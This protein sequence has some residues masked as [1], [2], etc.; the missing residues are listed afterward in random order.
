MTADFE[1]IAEETICTCEPANNGAGP[2]WCSGSPTIVRDG[3]RVFAT[4]PETG[5]DAKPLC[6]TRWQLFCRDDGATWQRV[7]VQ[8]NFCEREPCPLLLLPDGRLALS[9]N[10]PVRSLG[11][12]PDDP[13][14]RESCICQMNLRIF[15]TN[16]LTAQPTV[17]TPPWDQDYEFTEHSYRGLAADGQTG[18]MLMV[19]SQMYESLPWTYCD[20]SGNWS[21]QGAYHFP[22]RGCYQRVALRDKA[23]CMIAVSDVV[24]P[25]LQWRQFKQKVTGNQWSYDFRQIFFTWTPDLT[26]T[27][28]SPCLTIASRDETAG[29]C[30]GM[31]LYVDAK[32]DAHVIYVDTNIAQVYLRNEFFPPMPIAKSLKYCRLRDGQVIGRRTLLEAVEDISQS[33]QP[34]NP[35]DAQP[36]PFT[37]PAPNHAAFHGCPDG[38]L[39]IIY[40]LDAHDCDPSATGNYVQ[41]VL[42]D[43]N[44]PPSKLDLQYPMHSFFTASN[45]NGTG[46]S[47]T[48]DLFGHGDEPNL[49]RYAQVKID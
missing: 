45:R 38:S 17:I 29:S 42:P 13:D 20:A 39:Y 18:E 11:T 2:L 25:N 6:N 21:Q 46:R 32:G 27:D 5:K 48:I 7:A 33:T 36:G 43:M 15:D 16:D 19:K 23:A 10:P 24:E 31:D 4:V 3:N 9:E 28:F 47:H 1:T 30:T 41:R 37:S 34:E 44:Q 35:L 14:G 8:D 26:T 22:L 12:I 49:V 40:Y